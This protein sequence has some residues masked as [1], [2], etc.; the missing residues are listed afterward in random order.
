MTLTLITL[1]LVA[2]AVAGAEPFPRVPRQSS[3]ARLRLEVRK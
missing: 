1:A 2:L 3:R